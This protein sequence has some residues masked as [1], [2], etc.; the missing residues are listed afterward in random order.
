MTRIPSGRFAY[1]ISLVGLRVPG[2][3]KDP[4]RVNKVPPPALEPHRE[5]EPMKATVFEMITA[6]RTDG[7]AR[8][9]ILRLVALSAPSMSDA[10]ERARKAYPG[11]LVLAVREEGAK[12]GSGP[13]ELFA[14]GIAAD[15]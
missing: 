6:A 5:E 8:I 7:I 1:A 11:C 14:R 10:V 13:Q 3:G 9:D 2:T 12:H 4:V 15:M